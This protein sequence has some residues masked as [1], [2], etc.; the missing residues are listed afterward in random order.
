V[1][2][3]TASPG[4]EPVASDGFEHGLGAW[5]RRIGA[6]VATH[7]AAMSGRR[8]LRAR[9]G[10]GAPA[11]V[12]RRL[13]YVGSQA[14]LG[15]DLNPRSFSSAGA[16]IEI[17]VITSAS[18]EP[19]ASVD[20]RSLGRGTQLR[21]SASPGAGARVM[22]H[23]RPRLVGRRPTAFVLSLDSTQAGLAVDG[24]ELG[25]LSLA[26][27]SPQPAGIVLGP[28]RGGPSAS[29]GYLDFDRVTVREAPAA[30]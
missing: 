15:F 26:P 29:T 19:L 23:S 6:V 3:P 20:L 18:G 14:E 8:G 24:A 5:T 4:L 21:L 1:A 16:W 27:N 13:P 2:A 7:R 25:R 28:W 12:Q 17:A 22:A 11:F 10:A 9:L 30:S